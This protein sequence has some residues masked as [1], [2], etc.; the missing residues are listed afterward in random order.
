MDTVAPQ[1]AAKISGTVGANGIYTSAVG[2]ELSATD[3]VSGV[4]E[5]QYS[6]DGVAWQKYAAGM[7]FSGD[8]NDTLHYKAKDVAGNLETEHSLRS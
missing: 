8:G 1:S 6:T 7:S 2:I 3:A 4:A 5:I